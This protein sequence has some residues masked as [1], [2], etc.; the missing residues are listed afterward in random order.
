MFNLAPTETFKEEVKIQV[1]TDSG[2]REESFTGV[3]KRT[4]ESRREELQNTPFTKLVDE[5]LVDW[6]MKDL[7]RKPVDFTPE[8]KS[9]FL[10]MTGAVRETAVAY[11]RANAGAK[12]K[13]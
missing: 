7:E 13:N 10:E 11:L 3:F 12:A 6:D 2:W 1:K 8:H 4:P 5:V 9:I